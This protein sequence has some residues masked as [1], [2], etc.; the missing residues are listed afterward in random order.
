MMSRLGKR[1]N[2]GGFRWWVMVGMGCGVGGFFEGCRP[3][4]A[5]QAREVKE[6]LATPAEAPV[7]S[8][9]PVA[10]V[11]VEKKVDVQGAADLARVKSRMEAVRAVELARPAIHRGDFGGAAAVLGQWL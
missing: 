7:V 9:V 6:S 4:A 1:W 11:E 2:G 3:A 5:P 8:A 10:P